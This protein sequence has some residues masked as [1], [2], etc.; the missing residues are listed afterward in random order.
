MAYFCILFR[1]QTKSQ[2]SGVGSALV[3]EN[4]L[5]KSRGGPEGRSRDHSYRPWELEETLVQ[6]FPNF[7]VLENHLGSC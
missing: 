2:F 6:N 7:N 3:Y 4:R 1:E 5:L